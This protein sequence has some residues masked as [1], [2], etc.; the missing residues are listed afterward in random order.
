[1]RSKLL[2]SF[3]FLSQVQDLLS[4]FSLC[5][6]LELYIKDYVL[7]FYYLLFSFTGLLFYKFVFWKSIH[8]EVAL[9]SFCF[10]I[11]SSW[12][13]IFT[14]IIILF[15]F[16]GFNRKCFY[17]LY[18]LFWL[19]GFLLFFSTSPVSSH[20]VVLLWSDGVTGNENYRLI[21]YFPHLM[22]GKVQETLGL[23]TRTHII[24][25]IL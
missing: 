5:H 24:F 9:E 1:M 7:G 18:I 16:T 22:K 19:T 13:L 23:Q 2:L 14:L 20:H 3:Y 10:L 17:G 8:L 12:L 15:I 25:S 6:T 21:S 11:N 4:V